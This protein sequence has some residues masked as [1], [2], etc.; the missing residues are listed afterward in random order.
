MAPS[1]KCEQCNRV[2]RCSLHIDGHTNRPIYL[3]KRCA[4]ELGYTKGEK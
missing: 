1:L 2:A 3:C 4:K